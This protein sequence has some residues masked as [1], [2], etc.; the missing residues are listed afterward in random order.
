MK[1][2]YVHLMSEDIYAVLFN[3]KDIV[4]YNLSFRGVKKQYLLI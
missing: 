1:E 2:K 4:Y 3:H